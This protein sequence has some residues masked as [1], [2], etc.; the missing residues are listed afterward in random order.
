MFVQTAAGSTPPAAT[1]WQVPCRPATAHEL[2]EVQLAAA[3]Q[4]PSVQLP[5]KHSVAA[6]QAAPFALRSVQTFDMHLKPPA[7]SPSPPH[8][9]R[10]AA[11]GPQA[12][13]AQVMGACTQ[14]PA[15]LQLPI[16]VNVDPV[17]E[18]APQ[19]VVGAAFRQAPLPS[20]VPLN[21]Q[22]GFAMQPPCGS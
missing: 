3:Q 8:V 15:P 20:Q 17:Q 16:G 11:A 18:A 5:L 19:L 14:A 6:V 2:Q 7:Q 10:Q 12:K 22:G 21:P 4:N 1:G 9:V 13:G